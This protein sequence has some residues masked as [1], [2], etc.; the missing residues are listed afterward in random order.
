MAKPKPTIADYFV[1]ALSPVLIMALVGSLC[2]FLIDVRYQGQMEGAL[3]W[4]MF[5]FVLAI[6]LISRIAIEQT[7]ERAALFGFGLGAAL[8]LYLIRTSPAYLLAIVLMALVWY[9]AH[10]LVFDCTLIDDDQDSSGQGLLQSATLKSESTAVLTKAATGKASPKMTSKQVKKTVRKT[11]GSPGRSV[12]FFSLAALPL[13]GLGQVLLPTGPGGG[14][15]LGFALLVIYLGAALGLLVTT[16]FL[17]LRRYLR[18]RYLV[19]PPSIAFAWV[20]FGI[21]IVILVLIGAMY[22]PRPG[23]TEAWMALRAQVDGRL[24]QASQFA[25]GKQGGG[26]GNEGEKAGSEQE[27]G[28]DEKAD[29]SGKAGNALVGQAAV[30]Y[31][32]LRTVLFVSVAILAGWWLVRCRHLFL[33]MWRAIVAAIRKFLLYDMPRPVRSTL[34]MPEARKR[35]PLNEF[36]NPFFTD[37]AHSRPVAEVIL[38]TFEALQAWADE[39]GMVLHP[40]QTAREFCQ[41]M[42]VE[43]PEWATEV[44][45]LSYLHAHAAYGRSLPAD[46]NLEPLKELWR[47]MTY[48]EKQ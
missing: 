31:R 35:R 9:C 14:R 3:C 11:S 40:E 29:K 2:F 13:F 10:K 37:Q 39:H 33:E 20:K 7:A 18:Q 16:S 8:W 28:K 34:P 21:G 43:V 6:V 41:E 32:L 22:V 19:M 17:G 46:C 42:A 5:W 27:S 45:H 30:V 36:S 1:I 15:R 25:S 44:R 23:A 24:R 47:Q 38:Y 4:V 26:K 48:V 12:L